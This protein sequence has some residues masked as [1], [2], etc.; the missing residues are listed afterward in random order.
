MDSFNL[1]LLQNHHALNQGSELT[2][3]LV[4]WNC[5][6]REYR[7]ISFSN[8]MIK[9]PT[10]TLMVLLD[11]LKYMVH[12]GNVKKCLVWS[13]IIS[14][15]IIYKRKIN[16]LVCDSLVLDWFFRNVL[17]FILHQEH[18]LFSNSSYYEGDW[19]H[20]FALKNFIFIV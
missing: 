18:F 8:E 12:S 1:K 2:I 15:N 6:M 19:S 17:K 11:P 5:N 14:L 9:M 7:I 4:Q 20:V 10:P 13:I 3:L 16:R